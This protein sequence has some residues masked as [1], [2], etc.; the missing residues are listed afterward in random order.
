[1]QHDPNP[2]NE[3]PAESGRPQRAAFDETI[4]PFDPYIIS[5]LNFHTERLRRHL[6]LNRE[7]SA[8][9]FSLLA[10]ELVKASLRYNPARA[11]WHTFASGSLHRAEREVVRQIVGERNRQKARRDEGWLHVAFD[12]SLR[13]R[14]RDRVAQIRLRLDIDA[15]IDGLPEP[16]RGFARALMDLTPEE[17]ARWRGLHRSTVYR[18]IERLR[19]DPALRA[20]FSDFSL[21]QNRDESQT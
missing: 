14:A 6:R 7:E 16:L 9:A 15:A 2:A 8:D 21:R 17:T 20:I 5:R 3:R 12:A 10:A 4:T 13:P 1:M 18:A 11:S 19:D